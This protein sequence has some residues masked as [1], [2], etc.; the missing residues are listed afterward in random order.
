MGL[1]AHHR[2]AERQLSAESATRLLFRNLTLVCFFFAARSGQSIAQS[3]CQTDSAL[4]HCH[5]LFA[6]ARRTLA[7]IYAARVAEDHREIMT[8]RD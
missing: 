8:L 7:Q 4:D 5:W 1:T 6:I 3:R 2:T